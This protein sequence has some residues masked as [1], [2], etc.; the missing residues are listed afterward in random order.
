MNTCV[1]DYSRM[2]T[3]CE[4]VTIRLVWRA[5][6]AE[7]HDDGSECESSLHAVLPDAFQDVERKVD[8]EITQEHNAVTVL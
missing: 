4:R 1:C 3:A 8:V 6:A 2:S 5:A 7:S